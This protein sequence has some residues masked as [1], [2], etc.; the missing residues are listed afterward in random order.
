MVYSKWINQKN[1]PIEQILNSKDVEARET[2]LTFENC[3]WKIAMALRIMGFHDVIVKFPWRHPRHIYGCSCKYGT[4]DP[5]KQPM[6]FPQFYL[7]YDKYIYCPVVTTCFVLA[8]WDGTNQQPQ[9]IHEKRGRRITSGTFVSMFIR[10]NKYDYII[11]SSSLW[12]FIH[13]E[14]YFMHIKHHI[15]WI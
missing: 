6:R 5:S 2:F 1:T 3:T 13:Y 12:S 7:Q 10:C 4:I 15:Y 8:M 14:M 11:I 9:V